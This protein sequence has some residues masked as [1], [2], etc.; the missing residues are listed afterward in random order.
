MF[1]DAF[2]DECKRILDDAST[3]KPKPAPPLLA[4]VV[5]PPNDTTKSDFHSEIDFGGSDSVDTH[6]NHR[7]KDV[8][9]YGSSH[10]RDR[11]D[12]DYR[13]DK[14]KHR[15]DR[16]RDRDRERHDRKD[17]KYEKEKRHHHSSSSSSSYHHKSDKDRRDRSDRDTRHR[18]RDKKDRD[19]DSRESSSKYSSRDSYKKLSDRS[20]YG[21]TDM[22]YANQMLDY[23]AIPAGPAKSMLYDQYA[24]PSGY[25]AQGGYHGYSSLAASATSSNASS[26]LWNSVSWQTSGPAAPPEPPNDSWTSSRVAVPA[27][28]PLP[29]D[30]DGEENWDDEKPEPPPLP[31]PLLPP[32]PPTE[33]SSS[34]STKS[35]R[36]RDK[37][38]T[39]AAEAAATKKKLDDDDQATIDL[40][41]RIAMMFK[42]KSFG[43]APP[44]LQMDDSDTDAEP[45]TE[46]CP[47]GKTGASPDGTP[48]SP[49][50]SVK[51][52]SSR[53][54]QNR[55]VADGAS[56]ISSS[57]DEILHRKGSPTITKSKSPHKDDDK[58]SL[59]SLSSND[60][61]P[62]LPS[63]PPLPP[64]PK[65]QIFP[66]LP[67]SYMYPPGTQP[68]YY[69]SSG[70][71]GTTPSAG[72]YDLYQ[73]QYMPHQHTYMQPYMPGF[74]HLLH[75]SGDYM[76]NHSSSSYG[77]KSVPQRDP[78]EQTITTVIERV[79]AELKQI[80][81]KD[82]NK[83]MIENT[84]Y[85]NFETWWDEEKFK[86][87]IDPNVFVEAV[88]DTGNKKAPDIN[89][90][91]NSNLETF[92]N[93][94][95]ITLGLR[96]QIPKLPSFRRI[97]KQP[98]PKP[99]IDEE[100]SRKGFSDQEEMVQGSESETDE[101][102][103]TAKVAI[104]ANTN[105]TAS[106]STT[107][108]TTSFIRESLEA[109]MRK[110]QGSTSTITSSDDD[111]DDDDDDDSSTDGS[112]SDSDSSSESEVD[113]SSKA[114]KAEAVRS[115]DRRIYSDT[116]SETEK[117]ASAK[118]VKPKSGIYSDESS[119]TE[120]TAVV[121]VIKK[122]K[123][124]RNKKEQPTPIKNIGVPALPPPEPILPVMAA[125]SD[126]YSSQSPKPPRTPG[127]E[128]PATTETAQKKSI[129]D[130]DR[131]Y[132][133]SDEEREYQEKRR[134]NTQYMEEIER[135]FMEEQLKEQ[136][137]KSSK[138]VSSMILDDEEPLPE[139]APS[140]GDPITPNI[141]QPPPTPGSKI[142]QLHQ[143][144]LTTFLKTKPEPQPV[145]MTAPSTSA[146]A[147]KSKKRTA[148]SKEVNGI[149]SKKVAAAL[150][151]AVA[152]AAPAVPPTPPAPYEDPNRLL[153]LSPSTSSDG[154]SS[155]ESQASQ[156]SQ[157]AMEHCYS[158]P[159]SAS[160][161]I[162]SPPQRPV[163]TDKVAADVLAHDHGYTTN[164]T[165]VI[166]A[167]P[168]TIL[169]AEIKQVR[170]KKDTKRSLQKQAAA[171]A[172]ELQKQAAI[173]LAAE[174]RRKAAIF[175]PEQ[176]YG[177]RDLRDEMILLYEFLT[178]G[179]DRE[180]IEY[181]KQSYEY[182]L[183]DDANSYWLNA[184]HWMD[185]C[186][187][188][189]ALM[190]PPSKKRKREDENLKHASGSARTEGFYKVDQREK[191]MF[192]HHHKKLQAGELSIVPDTASSSKLVSKMQ[193]ASREARSNQRRLLTAFG[194]ST[195]SELLKFNQLK[196]RKK[197]LK[198][199]KSAIHDWGLFA[200]EPI[201]ADEMVI[202]YVG[203]MIRP[204]VADVREIKYGAIGIGS[205]YLF[206]IDLETI[207]D[208]TKC[209]NL[210]RFI[211]H[212]CNVSFAFFIVIWAQIAKSISR[213]SRIAM[214]RSL[215]SNR[216]RRLSYIRSNRLEL[217]RRSRTTTN[218]RWRTLR[219]L[220]CV[221]LRV[222]VAS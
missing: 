188:D 193:G 173:D 219:F 106:S 42:E 62:P 80:L 215:P 150:A 151:A 97:R 199:A 201:A 132:S 31:P 10:S 110:R 189:R 191:A 196:F 181:L 73:S 107:V 28:P 135:E 194:A 8:D 92:D 91:L 65:S 187:T 43:A 21:Q 183:Q 77:K 208:A 157:V 118:A 83:K 136:Q 89:Q 4:T 158:L 138:A 139:K 112:D 207:I 26:S 53:K 161:S 81:K 130:Y 206:R 72:T 35:Q 57:D 15:R 122:A 203:Q 9:R 168:P 116:E 105:S 204:A 60:E 18:D 12:D 14:D 76:G 13:L 126:D 69:S 176:R 23:Q 5:H 175:V 48:P 133:D 127:R 44:F 64:S 214:L 221:V 95:G 99:R 220:V 100:D 46:E 200:M 33:L 49:Y 70:N 93:Y 32:S 159:P 6:F 16:D 129:Y 101:P 103:Q 115:K 210:A 50:S 120:T 55:R 68:Y 102:Q 149:A 180:D 143:D 117:K 40:D 165:S 217:T 113:E 29:A 17:R 172:A 155:Q 198:F 160:P 96:A 152:L 111:H 190:P 205:S 37:E 98:S 59:S 218:F 202:E 156:A 144:P 36:R 192:K 178:K 166:V 78:Y 141:L 19:R 51:A 104:A 22:A 30:S 216:K 88:I 39:K 71:G 20:D 34:T 94:S 148:K 222:V 11:Y 63:Q 162:C 123:K 58:M 3:D 147:T 125:L 154:G 82:F 121:G 27:P 213:Y 2:G 47:K 142:L 54:E 131:I 145:K 182:L 153:K 25:T 67:S 128:S 79:T 179:I 171:A 66:P 170:P 197:Q 90:L 185:H 212:S 45:K 87:K 134:R 52:K 164:K 38:K 211:N 163:F 108:P 169:P 114:G 177:E 167:A 1:H 186:I 209:G 86:S 146:A 84:A 61:K 119:D 7:D 75:G 195:E 74:T 41:T 140:P 137:L 124:S 56:D 24:Y 85:K 109:K 174:L 184:T